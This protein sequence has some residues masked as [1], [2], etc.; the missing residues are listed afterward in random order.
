[1]HGRASRRRQGHPA[2]RVQTPSEGTAGHPAPAGCIACLVHVHA[3]CKWSAKDP[4]GLPHP[5]RRRSSHRAIWIRPV[6]KRSDNARWN[7][8]RLRAFAGQSDHAPCSVHIA[9]KVA[10]NHAMDNET[11]PE[12]RRR[13]ARHEAWNK[14]VAA[15]ETTGG[16][17]SGPREGI[18]RVRTAD[19]RAAGG[20]AAGR[21]LTSIDDARARDRP[22]T[23]ARALPA[24][25]GVAGRAGFV[26]AHRPHTR[27]GRRNAPARR[28]NR[29]AERVRMFLQMREFPEHPTPM[30]IRPMLRTNWHA[31]PF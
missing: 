13:S 22:A 23:N 31:G 17:L 19:V 5:G 25:D 1:M 10:A 24:R 27:I 7:R 20:I 30:N 2:L 11:V 16:R 18:H 26:A 4:H 14:D 21:M 6:L 9:P 12:V 8:K 28:H 3:S 15:C 29:R